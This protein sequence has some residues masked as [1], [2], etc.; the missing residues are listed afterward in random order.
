MDP[1]RVGESGSI[2]TCHLFF[3][4]FFVVVPLYFVY[5]FCHKPRVR[6]TPCFHFVLAGVHVVQVSVETKNVCF[7]DVCS[8]FSLI[9]VSTASL[10][11]RK[12]CVLCT[13][14]V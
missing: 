14:F 13:F 1:P 9:P 5:T 4:F 7:V 12:R 2:R 3:S 10:F 8:H 6:G 11:V